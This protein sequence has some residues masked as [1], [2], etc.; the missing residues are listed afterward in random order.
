MKT[1]INSEKGGLMQVCPKC[2][3]EIRPGEDECS[4]C[5][6]DL[7]YL[8]EKL[9]KE[10]A[11]ETEKQQKRENDANRLIEIINTISDSDVSRLLEFAEEMLGK[12]KRMHERVPCLI[13]TD[14][15]F[16]TRAYQAY[17]QDI[18]HGGVFIETN[19]NFSEGEEIRLTLSLAH[20]FKPFKINGEIVR[21]DQ[22]GV[23]IRFKKES[24]V[25][26]ELI[27]GLVAKVAEFK[28]KRAKVGASL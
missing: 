24:Q 5:G 23:G 1:G 13:T 16:K 7:A 15:V 3:H 28:K 12:K 11:E 8:A 2:G 22:K 17:I 20:F 9:A 4:K 18:S 6:T 21:R 10:T 14:Y 19:E 25:Q 27:K 26:E